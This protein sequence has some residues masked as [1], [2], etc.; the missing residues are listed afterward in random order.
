MTRSARVTA[1]FR[2][3]AYAILG[4]ALRA[5][6]AAGTAVA[7]PQEGP[8]VTTP[9]GEA[10]YLPL[11][12]LVLDRWTG[13]R[14]SRCSAGQRWAEDMG[15]CIGLPTKMWFREARALESRAWRLPSVAELRTLYDAEGTQ[16][17]DPLAFPDSPHTW[18]WAIGQ[19]GEAAA[20][21]VPCGPVAG[22][23]S[24]Y[25]SD[26]RAVRLVR[27]RIGPK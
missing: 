27:R 5:E 20:W 16:L 9:D 11:G 6:T 8:R 19:R 17:L 21:G 12:D 10:R 22:N 7:Q 23:D 26:A 1:A 3:V 14:W 24:C 15:A 2:L 4:M 18:F 13:L 25:Q